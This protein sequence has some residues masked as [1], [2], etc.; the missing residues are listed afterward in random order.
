MTDFLY[1]TALN[2]QLTYAR[3]ALSSWLWTDDAARN[4]ILLNVLDTLSPYVCEL[5]RVSAEETRCGIFEDRKLIIDRLLHDFHIHCHIPLCHGFQRLSCADTYTENHPSGTLIAVISS[6]HPISEII[7]AAA[8]AIQTGNPLILSFHPAAFQVSSRT[9]SLIREAAVTAGAPDHCI[10]WIEN[11]DETLIEKLK[12]CPDI[13]GLI[14]AGPASG[15]Q[16]YFSDFSKACILTFPQAAFCYVHHSAAPDLTARQIVLSKT[17]DNG[18]SY[19]VEQ[20][21]F[22]DRRILVSLKE[23][24][25]REGCYFASPEETIRL[26]AILV[27][28]ST[29]S[30]NP[31][32]I[33][34]APQTLAALAEISI[35]EDTRLIVLETEPDTASHPLLLP[36]LCPV[37]IL[38]AVDDDEQAA[39]K[40]RQLSTKN[41]DFS[42]DSLFIEQK[43]LPVSHSLV[44]HT[45]ENTPIDVLSHALPNFTLIE[46]APAASHS[47]ALNYRDIFGNNLTPAAIKQLFSARS[48]RLTLPENPCHFYFPAEIY[49]EKNA[50]EHLKLHENEDHILFLQNNTF[51]DAEVQ[52]VIQKICQKY[53]FIKSEQCKLTDSCS[54]M[55]DFQC[56]LS[57]FPDLPKVPDCLIVIGD[58]AA[59]N[60]AKMLMDRYQKQNPS[61]IPRWIVITA[62]AGCHNALLPYYCHYNNRTNQLA[63]TACTLPTFTLIANS[64]FSFSRSR[65]TWYSSC[66]AAM[67]DAFD[68]LLSPRGDDLSDAMALNAI[69]LFMTYFPEILSDSFEKRHQKNRLDACLE[70]LQ[71]ACILSGLACSHTGSGLSHILAQQLCCEFRIPAAILQSILLPHLLLYYGD[72]RPSRKNWTFSAA[73][74]SANE[75]LKILI[76]SNPAID[77]KNDPAALLSGKLSTLL[78]E[79][80]LPANIK[81]CNIREKDYLQ[82]IDDLALRSFE[83]LSTNCADAGPRYPLVKELV[84]ILRDIY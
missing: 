33:G 4:R 41:C 29:Y 19:T 57:L 17:F 1:D 37:L 66:M 3:Q 39:D 78:E 62:D 72:T 10:Q 81:S 75:H 53:P 52:T 15:I 54:E 23:A 8:T 34:Q 45:A 36:L 50:L 42:T 59:V 60:I 73:S 44:I 58:T 67:A 79:A 7:F 13:S 56:Q 51:S 76:S 47:P 35:P 65:K 21:L 64:A 43:T 40:I 38:E 70:H 28:L 11:T 14:L 12:N 80:H 71:N 30:V 32:V 16:K 6:L 69:R 63:D 61:R 25:H 9:A 24:L 18:L 31:A 49:Y 2:E 5:A 82:R 77:E 74:Y 26:T 68:S 83:Q 84:Q 46:N 20:M 48:C 22:A 27:D 55:T